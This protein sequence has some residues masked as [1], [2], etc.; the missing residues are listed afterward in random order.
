MT[1]T[2]SKMAKSANEDDVSSSS[3]TSSSSS[4]GSSSWSVNNKFDT[5]NLNTF[6][7]VKVKQRSVKSIVSK[8]SNRTDNKLSGSFRR[9]QTLTK[10]D[11]ELTFVRGNLF[12]ASL[13]N[14]NTVFRSLRLKASGKDK[15][16]QEMKRQFD[17]LVETRCKKSLDDI[18][19][20]IEEMSNKEFVK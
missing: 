3:S 12:S 13:R 19:V 9:R 8:K 20:H 11:S 16:N 14:K 7:L 1:S 5:S 2:K 4:L 18:D 15:K 17:L 10:D 6:E